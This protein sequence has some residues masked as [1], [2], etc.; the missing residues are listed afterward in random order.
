MKE[1]EG[2]E[3]RAHRGVGAWP[4]PKSQTA[5]LHRA[6]HHVRLDI[7]SETRPPARGGGVQGTGGSEDRRFLEV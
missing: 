3:P 4:A 7:P 5:K 1:L 6:G 2:T